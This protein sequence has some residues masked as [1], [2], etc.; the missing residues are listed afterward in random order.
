MQ[1]PSVGAVNS[2]VKQA[3]KVLMAP[4]LDTEKNQGI[5]EVHYQQRMRVVRRKGRE[6]DFISVT[7]FLYLQFY[8][9]IFVIRA[10][11]GLVRVFSVRA[12]RF[13]GISF[14]A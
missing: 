12:C 5:A 13:R 7:V 9:T 2:G 11:P 3:R 8:P 10:I 1:K 14:L 4:F 6:L